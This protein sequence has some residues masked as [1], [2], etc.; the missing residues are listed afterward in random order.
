MRCKS[1]IEQP[2]HRT[3][4]PMDKPPKSR[5]SPASSRHRPRQAL[6]CRHL[7]AKRRP[8]EESSVPYLGVRILAPRLN[9]R[10]QSLG[11]CKFY[12]DVY[13][14]L[15]RSVSFV[16]SA[17]SAKKRRL[18][19]CLGYARRVFWAVSGAPHP[20]GINVKKGAPEGAPNV[21]AL[22]Q[23]VVATRRASARASC[24]S[25]RSRRTCRRFAA[26]RRSTCCRPL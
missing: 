1:T 14:A 19:I 24:P 11:A 22:S 13:Q 16:S 2:G 3:S 4:R 10:T 18:G 21:T 9:A 23:R 17:K 8:H 6:Q 25:R 15:C 26:P 20:T 12:K 5:Q 7:F